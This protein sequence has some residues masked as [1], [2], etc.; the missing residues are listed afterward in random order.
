MKKFALMCMLGVAG[1]AFT[2]GNA[3]ADLRG[4]FPRGMTRASH[5]LMTRCRCSANPRPDPIFP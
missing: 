4:A 2:A 3:K 5:C 1:L